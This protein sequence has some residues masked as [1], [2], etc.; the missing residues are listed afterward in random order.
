M[1]AC[2]MNQATE[3]IDLIEVFSHLG[4]VA[5]WQSEA[6]ELWEDMIGDLE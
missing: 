1:G 6:D 3:W 2:R 4:E 5:A